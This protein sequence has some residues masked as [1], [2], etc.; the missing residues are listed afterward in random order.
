MNQKMTKNALSHTINITSGMETDPG[1]CHLCKLKIYLIQMI[2]NG[3]GSIVTQMTL[4]AYLDCH[5]IMCWNMPRP[6]TETEIQST[7]TK[8][9]LKKVLCYSLKR[10]YERSPG[11]CLGHKI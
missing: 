10:G 3:C 8:Y 9:S 4:K 7:N 2:C 1:K 6:E 5:N 11:G